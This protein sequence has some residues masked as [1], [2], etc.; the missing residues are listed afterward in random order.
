MNSM[1]RWIDALMGSAILGGVEAVCSSSIL[2]VRRKTCCKRCVDRRWD[3]DIRKT[4]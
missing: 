2:V 1:M 4:G 3:R